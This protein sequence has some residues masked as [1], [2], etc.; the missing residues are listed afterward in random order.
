MFGKVDIPVLGLVA[1]MSSFSCPCCG[2]RSHIFGGG[3]GVRRLATELGV[4]V[5]ADVPL[6]TSITD[7]ADAGQPVVLNDARPTLV[8]S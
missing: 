2:Q 8:R 6:D 5:L 1:N 7:G 3:D 4:D